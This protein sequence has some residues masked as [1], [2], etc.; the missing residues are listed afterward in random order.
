MQQRIGLGF[1]P[2][3]RKIVSKSCNNPSHN[4]PS[5]NIEVAIIPAGS[6]TDAACSAPAAAAVAP[7]TAPYALAAS[8][9][10]AN[11]RLEEAY[12]F[13]NPPPRPTGFKHLHSPLSL[14]EREKENSPKSNEDSF[15]GTLFLLQSNNK[16]DKW[17][18]P[19]INHF[20]TTKTYNSKSYISMYEL[21]YYFCWAINQST[22][23]SEI[24]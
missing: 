24:L 15:R 13:D 4:H 21:T 10:P 6:G 2:C 19:S 23:W 1:N 3:D 8:D 18:L 7:S 14:S 20:A 22:P 9:M 16:L 11:L 12:A 5:R 17:K